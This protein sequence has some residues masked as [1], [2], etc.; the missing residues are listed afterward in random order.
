MKRILLVICFLFDLF[1]I[2]CAYNGKTQELDYFDIPS[3]YSYN[4]E[5]QENSYK[6][7][8]FS[9]YKKLV[10]REDDTNVDE[11]FFKENCLIVFVYTEPYSGN[12]R[13]FDFKINGRYISVDS[14]LIQQG[15]LCALQDNLILIKVKTKDAKYLKG[16]ILGTKRHLHDI[17]ELYN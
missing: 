4:E 8:S 2:G 7:T 3:F 15:S 1:A 14:E 5:L 9:D 6:I 12:I 13:D 16:I 11:E 10:R 17:S